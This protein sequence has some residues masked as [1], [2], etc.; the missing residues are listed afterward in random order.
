MVCVITIP[1]MAQQR[2]HAS[3]G[4]VVALFAIHLLFYYFVVVTY[5]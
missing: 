2:W 5:G 4:F 1:Y 3:C